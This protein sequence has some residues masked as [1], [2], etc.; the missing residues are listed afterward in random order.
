MDVL[1][2]GVDHGRHDMTIAAKFG[3]VGGMKH[4]LGPGPTKKAHTV[5]PMD[6]RIPINQSLLLLCRFSSI[7]QSISGLSLR[8]D[9]AG[10]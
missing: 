5:K 9:D 8:K 1:K 2:I 7:H 3:S 4:Q 6:E 10:G